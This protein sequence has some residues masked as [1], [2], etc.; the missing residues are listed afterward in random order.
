M[1]E[2]VK[3]NHNIYKRLLKKQ[4]NPAEE[5]LIFFLKQENF[6]QDQKDNIRKFQVLCTMFPATVIVL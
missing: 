3:E 2:K 4:E 5:G 1:S 6:D